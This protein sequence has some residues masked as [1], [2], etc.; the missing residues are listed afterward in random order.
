MPQI[1]DQVSPTQHVMRL[2]LEN[3][4]D[5]AARYIDVTFGEQIAKLET[6]LS[7]LR[8]EQ[9]LLAQLTQLHQR[10]TGQPPVDATR[11][12][13]LESPSTV[14]GLLDLGEPLEDV[15]HAIF[16][17]CIE[18]AQRNRGHLLLADAV[19]ELKKRGIDLK[20]TRPGTS[21]GNMLFKSADWDRVGDGLF[22]WNL[23]KS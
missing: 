13:Q 23:Y 6:K 1:E 3:H 12:A 16:S 11:S 7:L 20:S 5:E 18:L 14:D 21:I 15:R 10:R 22:R 17:M 8:K 19:A 2:I 4:V 9:A